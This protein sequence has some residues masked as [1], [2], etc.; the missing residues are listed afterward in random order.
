MAHGATTTNVV[1]SNTYR[2][3][4]VLMRLG[5]RMEE[6][7]GV[8]QATA[9]M[10]TPNN[11]MLMDEAGLLPEG[12]ESIGPN[13]LVLA[14]TVLDPVM[15]QDVAV[16]A[17]ALLTAEA[18]ALAAEEEYRPSTIDGALKAHPAANLAVV[19]VP[20]QYAAYEAGAA[21]SRG[22]NVFVF[23]DNVSLDEEIELKRRAMAL[24]LFMLGPDCGTAL[25][26]GVPLGFANVV[27]RGNIGLVSAS[28]TG[29]Q[30]VTCLISRGGGGVSHAL[31]VGGRDLDDRVGG[32]MLLKGLDAL[33]RDPATEVVV[34]ISKPPGPATLERVM[35]AL[36]RFAKPRVVCFLGAE[37]IMPPGASVFVETTLDS[38]ASRALALAGGAPGD[39]GMDPGPL[40]E[41]VEQLKPRIGEGGHFIKGIFSGG[42]LCYEALLELRNKARPVYSNLELAGVLPSRQGGAME[43]HVLLDLGHDEFTGGRPHPMIDLQPRCRLI[44]EAAD[45]PDVGVLLLDVVL[46]HGAHPDAASELGPAIAG[47]RR[48][49]SDHGR[50]LACVIVLVG[51][52][53]DPQGL[54]TQR[55]KLEAAGALVVAS[56]VRAAAIAAELCWAAEGRP[57]GDESARRR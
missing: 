19:S 46:G 39:Q 33:E 51:T 56:N 36:R 14:I 11:L 32:V 5:R 15:L 4:V 21:L 41:H 57:L 55:A 37:R 35:G 31:G 49:V 34:L 2:D 13:D 10:G 44:A 43:G 22:L 1:L 47:A 28:G 6:W 27:P 26:D 45:D 17:R 9:M 16:R 54:D 23:S 25:I 40:R 42:T 50:S 3:S 48:I 38:A 12:S 53:G 24:D 8:G 18:G 30:Q 7:S 29:L 52:S 20:G